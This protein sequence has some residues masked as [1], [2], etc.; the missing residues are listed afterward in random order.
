MSTK[1]EKT[2]EQKEKEEKQ[3]EVPGFKD[4]SEIMK[5]PSNLTEKER[6]QYAKFWDGFWNMHSKAL[7]TAEEGYGTTIK[8][9]VGE[10]EGTISYFPGKGSS[11]TDKTGNGDEADN[12]PR[13]ADIVAAQAILNEYPDIFEAPVDAGE[14]WFV[15]TAPYKKIDDFRQVN[16]R[17]KQAGF[18]YVKWDEEKEYS[19]GWKGDK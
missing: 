19:K 17:F 11:Y 2:F 14:F 7:E 5:Q 4:A 16:N 13:K 18:K 12:T 15:K 6:W 3:E 9:K 8:L 1:Q 10:F